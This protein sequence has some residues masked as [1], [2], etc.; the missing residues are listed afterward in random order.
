MM[1]ILLVG[2]LVYGLAGCA[3]KQVKSEEVVVVETENTSNSVEQIVEEIEVNEIPKQRAVYREAVTDR[4][5]L[6]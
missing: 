5:N 3:S 2:I 1:R 4:F 6:S